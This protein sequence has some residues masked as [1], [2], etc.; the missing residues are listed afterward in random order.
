MPLFGQFH[1]IRNCSGTQSFKSERFISE[2]FLYE[3]AAEFAGCADSA[4][5]GRRTG[6]FGCGLKRMIEAAGPVRQAGPT[7]TDGGNES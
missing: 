2:S 4:A 7:T 3:L 6:T 1:A 5:S